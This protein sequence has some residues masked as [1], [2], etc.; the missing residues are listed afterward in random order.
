MSLIPA[1]PLS[2]QELVDYY[3]IAIRE[4]DYFINH[5]NYCL[6]YLELRMKP[7]PLVSVQFNQYES[8]YV[9]FLEHLKWRLSPVCVDDSLKFKE[10]D[11]L[12]KLFEHKYEH[13]GVGHPI[14]EDEIVP[15]L[16]SLKFAKM[17]LE[18]IV[19]EIE[20]DMLKSI[21]LCHSSADKPVVRNIGQ[22]LTIRGSQVWL[23]E[24]EI[25]V[26]DSILEKIQE[27]ITKSD[28]LGIVLSKSSVESIWVKKEVEAALTHEIETGEVKVI[29]ILI[30]QCDIPLFLKPKKYADMSSQELYED[31]IQSIVKRLAN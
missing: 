22:A 24:A 20:A 18:E 17:T 15:M 23:D 31:G 28:Y 2:L 19:D 9:S 1:L 8:Y 7:S 30:E 5:L 4:C 14:N 10:S 16:N 26:G 13:S 6:G 29:P 11:A 3:K 25:L 12:K 27:G 21:F